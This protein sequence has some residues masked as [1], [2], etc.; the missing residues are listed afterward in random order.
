MTFVAGK[1]SLFIFMLF[2]MATIVFAITRSKRGEAPKIRR[3]AGLDSIEEGLG[4]ATEMGR[5][6]HYTPGL[7]DITADT[8]PQTF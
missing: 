4:R 3:I 6:V 1:V 7:S 8:A 5:P 2:A